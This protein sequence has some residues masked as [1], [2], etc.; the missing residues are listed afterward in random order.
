MK[1]RYR[2]HRIEVNAL[3]ASVYRRFESATSYNTLA[4]YRDSDPEAAIL[5]AKEF[6]DSMH[7]GKKGLGRRAR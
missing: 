7:R 4:A 3:G 1:I 2:G 6:I 5:K